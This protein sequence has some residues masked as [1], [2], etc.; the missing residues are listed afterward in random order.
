MHKMFILDT[1]VLLHD[2]RSLYAFGDNEVVI[3]S[4]VIEE[5]DG[6]KNDQNIIGRNAREIARELD[7]LREQGSLCRGISLSNGGRLHVEMNHRSLSSFG[8]YFHEVN[9]DNRILA[10]ALNLHVEEEAKKEKNE[11]VLVSKDVIMRIKADSLNIQSQD[12]LFDKI[13]Y[14]EEEY[15]GLLRID[16][17]PHVIDKVYSLGVVDEDE[18]GEV[19]DRYR[20]YPNMFLMLKDI[21]GTSKSAILR[22][23]L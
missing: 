3:P 2:P 7:K 8:E 18:L 13:E 19:M 21:Y 6:K 17:E 4:V 23:D 5:I 14:Y 1:S 11:V 22:Y 12:Y 15:E 16:V 20:L 10:V 9:N